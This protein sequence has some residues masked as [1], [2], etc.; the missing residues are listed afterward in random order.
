MTVDGAYG[1]SPKLANATF[2]IESYGGD[3]AVI[4]EGFEDIR[5][6]DE[7]DTDNPL[8]IEVKGAASGSGDGD[9]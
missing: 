4:I 1:P 8:V 9:V 5:V 2:M 3:S 7:D 6:D